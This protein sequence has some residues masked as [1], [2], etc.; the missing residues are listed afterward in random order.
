MSQLYASFVRHADYRQPARTP[1]AHLPHPLNDEGREQARAL[2]RQLHALCTE[3]GWS[4]HPRLHTSSLLRAWQT[5]ELA[6][7]TLET[8]QAT[9]LE[10]V[11]SEALAE[12]SVGS[13]ANLTVDEIEDCVREDPRF[14]P[15]PEGWKSRSEFR[16]PFPGC[17]S[18]A[19]AGER[20]ANYVREV[21]GTV[22]AELHRDTLVA[23]IGHGASIRHAGCAL[24]LFESFEAAGA[25]SMYHATPVTYSVHEDGRWQHVAGEWKPRKLEARLD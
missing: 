9:T 19:E 8:L 14:D 3:R 21:L 13:M 17:E 23:F 15:L 12:R 6:R 22:R 11:S 24:G 16:L 25:V 10:I 18:L 20:V 4:L 7:E 1:S 5:T 2:G